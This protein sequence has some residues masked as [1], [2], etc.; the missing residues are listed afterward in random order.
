MQHNVF[1]VG[2]TL[3]KILQNWI[4]SSFGVMISGYHVLGMP[5]IWKCYSSVGWDKILKF[6]F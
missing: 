4:E 1:D 2:T 5:A 6:Q 3:I